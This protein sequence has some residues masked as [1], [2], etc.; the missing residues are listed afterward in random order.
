MSTINRRTVLRGTL[1]GAAVTVALPFLDCFLNTNGTALAATGAQLP[2]VFGTW[3]QALG[4]TP[5]R[6]LPETVGRSYENKAEL[7]SLDPFKPR[8]NLI[9]GVK[10]FLDGRPNETHI[11][12]QQIAMTGAI[13][14]GLASEPSIDNLVADVIGTRTRFRSIEINLDGSRRSVSVR[15]GSASRTPA[16]PS[17]M[18]LY[19]RIFGPEFKDPN[20]ADFKPDPGVMARKSVLSAVSDARR[21]LMRTLDASDRARLD[22]YFTSVRQIEQQLALELEKPAPLAA[23]IVPEA[24]GESDVG[25][26]VDQVD[27][28]NKLFGAL[29]A[30]AVACGQTRVFNVLVSDG[31]GALRRPG[32][33][34]TWHGWTHEEP[35]DPKL[36][37]QPQCAWFIE[38]ATA[39]FAEFLRRLDATKEGQGSV[40]DRMVILWQTD[41]GIARSHTMDNLPVITIG[42]ANG[43][44]RTGMHISCPGDPS[45]RVGLTLQQALGVPV[46]SWGALSNATSKTL[47]EILA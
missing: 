19:T 14:V 6:W 3:F 26:S 37:Y 5:G 23:C 36:G 4:F 46:E 30:H 22:E 25:A 2:T 44:L 17:P 45:T 8:M 35:I 15:G 38:W 43:R 39:T 40:L 28:T 42:N 18:A 10:Y 41:H 16:E 32:S 27:K 9:S 33:T 31:T 21:E 7:K 12:G 29:M 20:A 11:T 1:S 24:P 34:E 47:T 13:P